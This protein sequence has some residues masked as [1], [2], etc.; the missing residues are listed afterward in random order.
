MM[1]PSRRPAR[2]RG[3]VGLD[4]DDEHAG[5]LREVV[6]ARDAAEERH[7]LAGD[8]EVAAPDAAVAQERRA[9]WR[10]RC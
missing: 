3:P 10:A 1:S 2:A 6:E 4:R 9:G 5:R 7:V 8:A